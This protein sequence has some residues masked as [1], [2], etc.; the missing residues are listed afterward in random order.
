MFIMFRYFW[1]SEIWKIRRK[2]WVCTMN[3]II[4]QPV[5]NVLYGEV[6]HENC[7]FE[8]INAFRCDHTLKFIAD[9]KNGRWC[10]N[11]KIINNLV[12]CSHHCAHFF[13]QP[14]IKL[15]SK[16]NLQRTYFLFQKNLFKALLFDYNWARLFHNTRLCL[17]SLNHT[18]EMCSQTDTALKFNLLRPYIQ[19]YSKNT[20]YDRLDL[21]FRWYSSGVVATRIADPRAPYVFDFFFVIAKSISM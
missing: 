3:Y 4:L 10:T 19:L 9:F 7:I 15:K 12:S 13:K 5:F 11:S 2:A 17:C 16:K 21:L 14:S 18:K 8:F 6:A 1:Y 20:F